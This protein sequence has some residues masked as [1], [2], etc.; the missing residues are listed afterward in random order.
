[1][2]NRNY[3]NCIEACLACFMACEECVDCCIGSDR[4]KCLRLCMDCAEICQLC[5]RLM[6][7]NSS[8]SKKICALC[9]GYVNYARKNVRNM[10]KN[11]ARNVPRCAE[12]VRICAAGLTSVR[13]GPDLNF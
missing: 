6:A 3:Q 12:N 13:K 7:R 1:M 5:A 9:A 10:T 11:I 2:K 8:I 4:E